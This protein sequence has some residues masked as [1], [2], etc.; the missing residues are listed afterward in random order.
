[1]KPKTFVPSNQ[2]PYGILVTEGA[3][4]N[5]TTMQV[6]TML[7]GGTAAALS[8]RKNKSILWAVAAW[9]FWP[10]VLPYYA[11]TGEIKTKKS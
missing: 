10:A 7:A 5:P 6:A 3:K 1:M 8:Y 11:L 9:A 4:K 2:I